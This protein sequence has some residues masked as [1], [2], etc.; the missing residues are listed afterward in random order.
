MIMMKCRNE[1]FENKWQRQSVWY[2]AEYLKN[3]FEGNCNE[4]II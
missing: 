4:I 3:I 1:G 2:I